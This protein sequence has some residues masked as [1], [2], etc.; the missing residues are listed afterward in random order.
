LFTAAVPGAYYAGELRH[1]E[2]EGRI[3]VVPVERSVPV[4]TAWDLGA[5]DSTAIWFIQQVASQIRLIDYYETSGL[6]LPHY[7][8]MLHE[9]KLLRK[10]SYGRHYFPHDIK[11]KELGTGRSRI[12]TLHSLG[13]EA[14][15]VPNHHVMDRID[16]TRRL[17]ERSWIDA[18]HCERGIEALRNYR[19]EYSEKNHDWRA[20]PLHSWASHGA[21]ALGYYA[22]G[23]EE[24]PFK[25][26]RDDRSRSWSTEVAG[27]SQWSA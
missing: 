22:M 16:Q 19:R 11:V 1:L 18:G 20:S 17:L 4:D 27:R 14:E 10:W 26:R 5:S 8:E 13:I 24:R 7:V 2:S 12:E 21:D 6:R 25:E 23:Y 3:G 9:K 15:V